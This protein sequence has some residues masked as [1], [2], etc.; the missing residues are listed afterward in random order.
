MAGAATSG[1][2]GSGWLTWRSGFGAFFEDVTHAAAGVDE[3][4]FALA[5]DFPAQ[6]GDED[7]DD[8]AFRVLIEVV[9]LFPDFGARDDFAGA[10]GEEFEERVFAGGEVD[11]FA[12]AGGG[13]AAGVD[14]EI[15][16]F[17]DGILDGV[18]ATGEG[19]DPS[20]E[21]VEGEGF[22]EV[23]VGTGVEACDAV[24]YLIA[25]G[26]DEDTGVLVLLPHFA[27]QFDAVEA[28]EHQVEDGD[29]V[30][31]FGRQPEPLGTVTGFID[32]EA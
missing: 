15:A 16:D 1:A 3:F 17:E 28:W 5:L 25:S 13:A 6:I 29:G 31:V 24:A 21:F 26:D 8:V 20:H 23:V 19:A 18:G 30:F 10:E 32:G 4:G 2:C 12:A 27:E 7:I 14:F 11:G 9:E 22:D